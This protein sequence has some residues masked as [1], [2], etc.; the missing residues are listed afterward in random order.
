[1]QFYIF[2]R[3]I[4]QSCLQSLQKTTITKDEFKLLS[5]SFMKN[6]VI[7][8]NI[9][10]ASSPQELKRYMVFINSMNPYNLV[11]DG[12][13]IAYALRTKSEP[14]SLKPVNKKRYK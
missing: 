8:K 3:G 5:Q 11:I 1:L 14:G 10:Y 2:Y 12:L 13:N 7:G 6:A 4:C 9:F